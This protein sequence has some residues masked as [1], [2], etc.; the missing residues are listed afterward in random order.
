MNSQVAHT[1]FP[2]LPPKKHGSRLI[3]SVDDEPLILLT[4]QRILEREGYAVVSAPNG[5]E[6]L[7]AFARYAVDL[8]L[9][10]YLM[11]DLD[12]AIV[13]EQIKGRNPRVP[14]IMTSA[15]S[16]PQEALACVDSFVSKGERPELLL[17]Q[18]RS[19][20]PPFFVDRRRA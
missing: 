2:P 1:D 12:G 15:N 3:L 20:L 17:E 13:A 4:R 11:P 10:D 16:V 19:L 6:A 18:I 8:V 14:I 5:S 7:Q 9:L